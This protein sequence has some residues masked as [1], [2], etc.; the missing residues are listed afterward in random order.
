MFPCYL[1]KLKDPV[2]DENLI[3]VILNIRAIDAIEIKKDPDRGRKIF[4]SHEVIQF[5]FKIETKEAPSGDYNQNNLQRRKTEFYRNSEIIAEVR[6][7]M[8]R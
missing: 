3:E 7:Y 5:R 6:K 4:S 2:G 1:L 8:V